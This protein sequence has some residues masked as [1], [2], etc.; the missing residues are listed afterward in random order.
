MNV[1]KIQLKM[2]K[3]KIKKP[4]RELDTYK[5]LWECLAVTSQEIIGEL[6][7]T[8]KQKNKIIRKLKKQLKNDVTNS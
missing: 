5:I 1:L 2:T 7:F 8:I 6:E 3:T 4:E